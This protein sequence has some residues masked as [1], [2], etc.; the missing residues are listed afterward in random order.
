M[1]DAQNPGLSEL[2]EVIRGALHLYIGMIVANL[3]G[4]LYWLVT[5]RLTTPEDVGT[6]SMVINIASI[7]SG[8][9]LLGIPTGIQRLLGKAHAE[10]NL[11]K[12]R[13]YT[14]SALAMLAAPSAT[15]VALLL[16]FRD[17]L[18][19]VL[20]IPGQFILIVAALVIASN[21][22]SLFRALYISTLRTKIVM[23]VSV[24]SSTARL[25]LGVTLIL[26]GLKA[27]G[28][29]LGYLIPTLVALTAYTLIS[30][31]QALFPKPDISLRQAHPILQAGIVTWIPGLIYLL[32]TN[33]GVPIVYGYHGAHKAG[34]YSIAYAV[35]TAVLAI[36]LAIFNIA[37]PV[38]SGMKDMRK[39]TTWEA[40]KISLLITAP[41]TAV[42][43][44]YGDVLLATLKPE[45]REA[46][47]ALAVLSIAIIPSTIATG[48]NT[49]TYA[50]GIYRLVLELGLATN[51]TRTTLYVALTPMA[52]GRGAATAFLAGTIAGMATAIHIA[53][54]LN[55]RIN[56]REIATLLAVP[57]TTALACRLAHLPWPL[58]MPLILL[59]PSITYMKLEVIPQDEIR[60]LV[61]KLAPKRALLTRMKKPTSTSKDTKAK[62]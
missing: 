60:E 46:H 13:G 31:K 59:I 62:P 42:L 54:K 37:Y 32:G 27:L 30:M 33:L 8:I 4:Y 24:S 18:S 49:L 39:R 57:S 58:G 34:L 28:I 16:A 50:Y 12:L 44:V 25:M 17:H 45:Y 36:P 40:M 61:K 1:S 19:T 2:A 38:L 22:N 43:A 7:I 9:T 52:G 5:A 56:W 48:I 21:M 15:T 26:L 14:A 11:E 10:N 35:A 23:L 51:I 6:A 55:F 20:R 29:A 53:K 47:P 3:L 41:L